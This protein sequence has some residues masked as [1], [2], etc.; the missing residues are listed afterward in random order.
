MANAGVRVRRRRHLG[1]ADRGRAPSGECRAGLHDRS[2]RRPA[3]LYAHGIAYH[4]DVKP[5]NCL[6]DLQAF[7]LKVADY[8]E[9]AHT[10]GYAAPELVEGA[11][12]D[13]RVDVFGVGRTLRACTRRLPSLR[14]AIPAI[15]DRATR[16]DPDERF[17]TVAD[18]RAVLAEG[19]RVAT[20]LEPPSVALPLPIRAQD[21]L[22]ASV[23]LR[24][25]GRRGEA[26]SLLEG[27]LA[28]GN[29]FEQLYT[30]IGHLLHQLG[31]SEE[32]LE[33]Y[34]AALALNPAFPPSLASLAAF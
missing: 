3:H 7:S 5:E 26:L 4:G 1:R 29:R 24:E 19:F 6:L 28:E 31:R 18:L 14:S 33:R 2:L 25:F 11:P 23:F 12:G 9:R 15:V 22:S 20:G 16:R 30:A 17:S 27:M 8:G 10:P 21:A 34:R 32:A 13:E